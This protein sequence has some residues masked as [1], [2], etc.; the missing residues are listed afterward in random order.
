LLAILIG[1]NAVNAAAVTLEVDG[2]GIEIYPGSRKSDRYKWRWSFRRIRKKYDLQQCGD[3]IRI[4]G[5]TFFGFASNSEAITIAG[6]A[7][8]YKWKPAPLVMGNAGNGIL[9][10][11]DLTNFQCKR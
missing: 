7:I 4:T 9:I 5:G 6:N 3:G 11:T 1:L 2:I 10:Q 8:V